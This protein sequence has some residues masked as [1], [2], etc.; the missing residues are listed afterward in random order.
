MGNLIIMI[1]TTT[2]FVVQLIGPPFV[3]YAV[4]KAEEIGLNVTEED[5]IRQSK[6]RDAINLQVPAISENMN[7]QELLQI[8]SEHDNFY[9]PVIDQ[10]KH[11]TGIVSIEHIKNVF[12]A[13][14]LTHF[15]IVHDI[16]IPSFTSCGPDTPL[17]TVQELLKQNKTEYLPVFTEDNIQKLIS[18]K[19]LAL[20]EKLSLM[21]NS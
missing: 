2:T 7:I 10:K 6:A 19:I 9:Y 16:M 21:S 4:K 20:Q 8:I 15:L 14:E 11:L 5:L 1:I 12:M 13:A 17:L 18:E 3:R